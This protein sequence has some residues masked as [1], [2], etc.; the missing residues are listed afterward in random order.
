M[1]GFRSLAPRLAFSGLISH[2]ETTIAFVGDGVDPQRE[3]AVSSS[4]MIVS[5]RDLEA[6]NENAV[7]LGE[8]LAT[9]MGARVGDSVVLLATAS[10]GSPSAV[11]VKVVGTFAT[12]YKD[13][14][15][16][17]LRLPIEVA[18]KLMRVRGAT[19]WVVLLDKTERTDESSAFLV[20]ALPAEA[21]EVVPWTALADFYNKTVVLFSKQVSVVKFII[22]LIIVLT[23]SNAQ[24]MSVL[25]RTTEI[26]TCLAVGQRRKSLML[27]FIAEGVMIGL[28]GGLLGVVL[29]Y[30]LAQLISAIGI[31]MPPPPGM[32]RGFVGQ[33]R[34]VPGLALDALLLAFVTTLLASIMPAWKASHMNIVDALRY[35][36]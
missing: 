12:S 31:P 30:L 36:R 8:G 11:E 19:S 35:N 1:S 14:D 16:S 18:R 34:V 4:V 22:G 32:A 20:K 2:G 27:T 17:A 23:I 3:R 7:L 21:F 10:N 5:G 26:G 33:I 13:Y 9:G 15:D 25:E 28:A 6:A 24:M 29:G